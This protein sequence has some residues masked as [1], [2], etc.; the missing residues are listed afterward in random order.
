MPI[1]FSFSCANAT[2]STGTGFSTGGALS[3][4]A[5]TSAP[6]PPEGQNYATYTLTCVNQGITASAQCQVQ[7]NK[8]GIVLVTNPKT[9]KSGETSLIGWITAG[10]QS[11]VVSSPDQQDFTARN[12]NNT[13]ANGAATTSPITGT[14]RF[15]LDCQTATGATK[16]A[17]TTVSLN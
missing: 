3:G 5:T 17:T 2:G 8:S 12:A 9:V 13:S 1:S 7:L 11:C 10:M 4:N 16:T 6:N 15:Q 14:A